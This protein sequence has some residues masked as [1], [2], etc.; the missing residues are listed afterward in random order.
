MAISAV[1]KEFIEVRILAMMLEVRLINS[2][3]MLEKTQKIADSHA[4]ELEEA[5]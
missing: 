4:G 3:R 5:A 1:F 2:C